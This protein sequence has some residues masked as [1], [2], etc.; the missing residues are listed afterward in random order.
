MS[1]VWDAQYPW[2]FSSE[3]QVSVSLQGWLNDA[4]LFSL[5]HQ[6]ASLL[7]N[8]MLAEGLEDDESHDEFNGRAGD[9]LDVV[10]ANQD[11]LQNW[12]RAAMWRRL[13]SANPR[14]RPRTREFTDT[15]YM[16]A[17]KRP[18]QLFDGDN[19]GR[20]LIRERERTLKGMRARLSYAEARDNRRGYPTSARLEFRW[21]Q[22]KRIAVDIL[23]PLGVAHA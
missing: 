8:L 22:V 13:L 15:W 4:R 7:Y 5:V 9:W 21:S 2:G 10:D 17:K 11:E 16:L 14:L 12:D 3:E 20:R 1:S 18:L 6:G 19:E 23:A